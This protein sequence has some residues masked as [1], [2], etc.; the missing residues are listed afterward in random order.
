LNGSVCTVYM[1][2]KIKHVCVSFIVYLQLYKRL[3]RT[4]GFM[5]SFILF[6]CL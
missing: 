6:S 5:L 3:S 1:H 4:V 2:N